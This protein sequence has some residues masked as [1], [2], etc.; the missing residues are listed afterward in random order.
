MDKTYS[1][2][3]FD[4]TFF[5]SFFLSCLSSFLPM[6]Q[7]ALIP[8][9]HYMVSPPADH[10]GFLLSVRHLLNKEK[11]GAEKGLRGEKEMKKK[12]SEKQ[13]VEEPWW[14]KRRV[15]GVRKREELQRP[16]KGGWGYRVHLVSMV[17]L[18]C[19]NLWYEPPKAT[20][21][22]ISCEKTNS[23]KFPD[24]GGIVI[25]LKSLRNTPFARQKIWFLS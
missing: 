10:H 15:E 18:Y 25:V 17:I 24:G 22:C 21:Y 9:L 20:K 5:L 1:L 12:E 23:L 7:I 2:Y 13:G 19:A 6:V 8:L 4:L 11:R 3:L 16:K 14:Q